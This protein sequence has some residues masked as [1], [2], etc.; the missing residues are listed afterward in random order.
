MENRK[1]RILRV[2]RDDNAFS[3]EQHGKNENI[4]IIVVCNKLEGG[5]VNV[6]LRMNPLT[7][8]S[9]LV[10][11]ISTHYSFDWPLYPMS[12]ANELKIVS[13]RICA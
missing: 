13:M 12:S 11:I 5:D 10:I 3:K 6:E 8:N 7:A 4:L 9:S 2:S 1:S